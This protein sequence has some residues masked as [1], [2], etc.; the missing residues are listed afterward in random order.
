MKNDEADAGHS[1]TIGYGTNPDNKDK[2]KLDTKKLFVSFANINATLK[3][4]VSNIKNSYK[5]NPQRL[6]P[7]CP[8]KQGPE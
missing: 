2:N 5:R 3:M 4:N 6:K 8:E 1:G 7:L